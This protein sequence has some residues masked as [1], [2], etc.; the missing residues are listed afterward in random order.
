LADN[1]KSFG[2]YPEKVEGFDHR[3]P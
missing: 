1:C 2:T 3:L